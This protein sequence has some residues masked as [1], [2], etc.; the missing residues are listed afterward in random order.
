[1]FS[2]STSTSTLTLTLAPTTTLTLALALRLH[3]HLSIP[4]LR[5]R[6][7][8]NVEKEGKDR[9]EIGLPVIGRHLNP[10]GAPL[11]NLGGASLICG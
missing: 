2:T 1:M 5:P 6:Q 4:P 7:V 10:G 11:T 3:P 9:H 8:T